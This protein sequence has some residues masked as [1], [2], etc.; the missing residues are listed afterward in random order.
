[1][2]FGTIQLIVV[3]VLAFVVFAVQVV[4]LADAARRPASA[5]TAE[6]KLSKNV[7][8]IILGVAALIGLLGLPPS[9]MTSGSFLNLIA[10]APAVIYWVDVRPRIRPYGNGGSRKPRGPQGGW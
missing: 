5:Y 6:G 2:S 8:L 9:Y 10:V 3:A 4:A 7:W 1:V